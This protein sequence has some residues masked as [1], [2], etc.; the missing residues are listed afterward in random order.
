M[1]KRKIGIDFTKK[2]QQVLDRNIDY[3]DKLYEQLSGELAEPTFKI[4][5]ARK[6]DDQK[7]RDYTLSPDFTELK[8]LLT[9]L[10]EKDQE[11]LINKLCMEMYETDEIDDFKKHLPKKYHDKIPDPPS[12][13]EEE[14]SEYSGTETDND[15]VYY[16]DNDSE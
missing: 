11:W 1:S 7:K 13:E 4:Y 3:T 8:G 5:K 14:E 12:S 2:V 15:S 10:E 9:Y 16:D 6:N